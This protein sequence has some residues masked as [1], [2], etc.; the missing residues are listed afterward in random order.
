MR[1]QNFNCFSAL[2][3]NQQLLVPPREACATFAF[4]TKQPLN[5]AVK[6]QGLSLL[7]V[8]N[9]EQ[10]PS[11]GLSYIHARA[12]DMLGPVTLHREGECLQGG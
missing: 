8:S 9:H 1:A 10:A 6:V 7:L 11:V 2:D 5:Q 3:W 12:Q 4:V